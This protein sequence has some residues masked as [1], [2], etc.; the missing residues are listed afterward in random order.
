MRITSLKS[1]RKAVAGL[2]LSLAAAS[3]AGI[4]MAP[5]ASAA[6]VAATLSSV[7]GP[8]TGGNALTATTA[9]N[10]FTAGVNFN[11]GF[12]IKSTPTTAC[13]ANYVAPGTNLATILPKV[14]STKKIA[15]T[16]PSGVV[17]TTGAST[18]YNMCAYPGITGTSALQSSATYTVAAAPSITGISS[19]GGTPGTT[20]S[21]P[22]LGG[23]TLTITGTGFTGTATASTTSAKIGS[24]SLTGVVY[25][26]A[27][28]ITGIVP[29]QAAAS[30]LSVSVTNTGGTDSLTS[31]YSYTNGIS[32]SPN[33][34]PTNVAATDIDI[35]GVGFS[36]LDFAAT[37]GSTPDSPDAHAYLVDGAYSPLSAAGPVKT[38]AQLG[39]C[40]D[41]LVIGDDELICT[42]DTATGSTA[43]GLIANGTYTVTVVNNGAISAQL[44]TATYSQ[45]IVSSGSTFT[46]APY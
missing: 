33:T 10:A 38:K 36:A 35:Q 25:V 46:V 12:Y 7:S 5:T 13:P 16:V 45:S 3:I 2:S 26:N 41:V 1:R 18:A 11:V 40:Q 43:G 30:G 4:A 32:V 37:D 27:T 20:A 39:E 28:T 34:A 31:A 15:F 22:A 44:A 21:G 9:T 6:S 14:L 8:T 42:L 17:L 19:S 29:P 23:G 24:A